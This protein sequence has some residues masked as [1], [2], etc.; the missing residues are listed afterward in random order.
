MLCCLL[1]RASNLPNVKK[2]RRSDP[3]A[4]LIFRGESPEA[5]SFRLGYHPFVSLHLALGSV[6][7]DQTR[8]PAPGL[9]ARKQQMLQSLGKL[10]VLF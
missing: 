5:T 4:S 3:V 10:E 2:D 6:G 1:A 8:N 9:T 7:P